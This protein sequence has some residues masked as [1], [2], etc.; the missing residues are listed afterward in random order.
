MENDFR[1]VARIN[2]IGHVVHG[3]THRG[4]HRILYEFYAA[5]HFQHLAQAVAAAARG[6]LHDISPSVGAL[7]GLNI[8]HPGADLEKLHQSLQ[9]RL[10]LCLDLIR[11][12]GGPGIGRGSVRV[13]GF[14]VKVLLVK[15]TVDKLAVL[16]EAVR[17]RGIPL[18]T[19][20]LLDDEGTAMRERKGIVDSSR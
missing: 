17:I 11:H 3:Q 6:A 20:K 2:R 1:P 18:L 19:D 5:C 13:F 9:L 7:P 15:R 4:A 16:H 8:E 10:E 14:T 12:T